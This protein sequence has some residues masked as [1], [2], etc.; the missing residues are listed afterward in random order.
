LKAKIIIISIL[1]FLSLIS[2]NIGDIQA[3]TYIDYEDALTERYI[4]V[5]I[6]AVTTDSSMGIIG[7]ARIALLK[8]SQE[9]IVFDKRTNIDSSTFESIQDA[10][11]FAESLT[12]KN[13]NYLISYD[14]NS[15]S[16]SGHST[17]ASIATAAIALLNEKTLNNTAI[18]TGSIGR[19]GNF[20]KTGGIPIKVFTAGK[21][22]YKKMVIPEGQ[23][24]IQV[25]E[26]HNPDS[27]SSHKYYI[28]KEINLQ[29]YAKNNFAME[30]IEATHLEN[31]LGDFMR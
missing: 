31:V 16:V 17:G 8:E 11:Y 18:V 13:G 27:F 28:I 19:Q 7:R 30:L 15:G 24:M 25:Y 6:V 23:S 2:I 5:P 14:L 12:G 26:K 3:K 4:D 9:K 22:G 1:L 20:L 29:D 21:L 10:I